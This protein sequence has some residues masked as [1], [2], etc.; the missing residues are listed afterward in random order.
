M[1]ERVIILIIENQGEIAAAVT[2]IIALF[3]R[4]REK[5]LLRK[6]GKLFD[7]MPKK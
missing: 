1:V 6:N 5:K 7:D 3:V 2:S 4:N